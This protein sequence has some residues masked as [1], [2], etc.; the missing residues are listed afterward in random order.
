MLLRIKLLQVFSTNKSIISLTISSFV[1]CILVEI[2]LFLVR[3]AIT[4]SFI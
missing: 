1:P 3:F 2:F 4:F